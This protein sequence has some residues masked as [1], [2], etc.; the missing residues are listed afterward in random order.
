MRRGAWAGAAAVLA[1]FA[2]S[3]CVPLT[4]Q[5]ESSSQAAATA[6]SAASAASGEPSAEPTTASAVPLADLNL[7][8]DPHGYEGP[9]TATIVDAAVEVLDP[10][11]EP[12]LPVVATSHTRDGDLDVEVSDTSRVVAFD[13]SGSIAATLWALGQGD[14]LVGRD[15]AAEFPGTEDVPVVTGSSHTIDPEAVL[16]LEPTL[17]ITDGSIGPTDSIQQ[18]A[19]AGVPVV[20]VENESSFDGAGELARQ[21]SAALGVAEAGEDLAAQIAD[22]VAVTRAEIAAVAPEQGLRVMML[23]LRGASGIYYMFGEESGADDLVAGLSGVDVAAEIGLDG[24][25]PL[26]DEAMLAADPEVI[27]VM[28]HGIESVGGVD[29]LL[30]AKPAIALTSAGQHRRIVDM[31]DSELL[32]FGPRSAAILNALARAVYAPES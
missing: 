2:L 25:K 23:Y 16:E 31:A 29:G 27:L 9:S 30:D 1:A 3:A 14:S 22:Q 7:L 21:V 20:I 12:Q 28:T 4:P 6:G 19:D 11:P 10:A 13:M 8:A 15:V 5:A 18:I 32:A 24:M 17:V 26:T